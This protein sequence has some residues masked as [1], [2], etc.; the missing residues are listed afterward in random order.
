MGFVGFRGLCASLSSGFF[1]GFS[2]SLGGF[3][4][5]FELINATLNVEQLLLTGK[6]RMSGTGDMD[7]HQRVVFAVFPLDALLGWRCRPRQKR[8]TVAEVLEYR[9][10]VVVGVD[11]FLHNSGQYTD[12]AQR[13]QRGVYLLE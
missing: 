3:L 9:G 11:I 10:T 5:S 7:F 8:P 2:T 12:E 6:E 4:A 1:H 13:C